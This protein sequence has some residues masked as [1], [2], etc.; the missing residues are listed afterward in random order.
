MVSAFIAIP[1]YA[2]RL[3]FK[4][5]RTVQFERYLVTERTLIYTGKD[6]KEVSVP[7][8]DVDMERTAEMNAG[9]PVP[10]VLPGMVLPS[11]Q[12]AN[13]SPEP[14]QPSLAEIALQSLLQN[15]LRVY[16]GKKSDS[17]LCQKMTPEEMAKHIISESTPAEVHKLLRDLE[18]S[19]DD[20]HTWVGKALTDQS[21]SSIGSS[22][23]AAKAR[24]DKACSYSL[25][26]AQP[27][28]ILD[29]AKAK[30]ELTTAIDAEA[31]TKPQN[32]SGLQTVAG[33]G[34]YTVL[35]TG[36][37]GLAVTGTCSFAGKSVSFDD[38]L[39]AQH[40]ALAG[41]GI[42]CSFVKKYVQGTLKMQII[43]NGNVRN[44]AETEASYGVVSLSLDW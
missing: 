14:P 8:S 27:S 20:D 36:T 29:C 42:I 39:P 21:L 15:D 2:H 13:N 11:Q 35:L 26:S 12:A 40:I 33:S 3:V 4:D 34:D 18:K 31:R 38:V 9:E 5:G 7:L 24:A 28:E 16:C 23:S 1:L 41:R 32:Q 25:A 19:T 44:E 10:L 30:A 43:Q 6:G 22:V 17:K 37:T